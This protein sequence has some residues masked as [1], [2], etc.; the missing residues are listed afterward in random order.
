MCALTG[1]SS[2]TYASLVEAGHAS[3]H[4]DRSAV[5]VHGRRRVAA[6]RSPRD[7]VQA[8]SVS[9]SGSARETPSDDYA[10]TQA[11]LRGTPLLQGAVEE[12][13]PQA[14]RVAMAVSAASPPSAS[15]GNDAAA[16]LFRQRQL[17]L[18]RAAASAPAEAPTPPPA[19][20]VVRSRNSIDEDEVAERL[21][22]L[23]EV[24]EQRQRLQQRREAPAAPQSAPRAVPQADTSERETLPA[25]FRRNRADDAFRPSN[26]TLPQDDALLK[27]QSMFADIMAEE[28]P[29][30]TRFGRFPRDTRPSE[31]ERYSLFS[32]VSCLYTLHVL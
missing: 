17:A 2:K 3:Q 18:Q 19:P 15:G 8:V 30:P 26:D 21:R 5:G 27:R 20:A 29:P 1:S 6:P 13:R 7:T 16:F 22:L 4:T 28:R 9:T 25:R 10:R 23:A 24:Q 11:F 12:T 32:I 14:D 31:Y